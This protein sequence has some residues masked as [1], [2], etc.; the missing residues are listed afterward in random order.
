MYDDLYWAEKQIHLVARR[1]KIFSRHR[2]KLVSGKE[3]ASKTERDIKQER[4][5]GRESNAG[6]RKHT[7][8]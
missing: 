6:T 7:L 1:K 3:R 8:E 5:S 2:T 4:E